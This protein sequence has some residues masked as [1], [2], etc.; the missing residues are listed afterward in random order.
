MSEPERKTANTLR[1]Q[2]KQQQRRMRRVRAL[3]FALVGISVVLLAVWQWITAPPSG[4]HQ[5]IAVDIP[6][7]TRSP[8]IGSLLEAKGVI[9]SAYAFVLQTRLDGAGNELKAGRYTLSGDMPLQQVIDSL[10]RGPAQDDEGIHVTIPEGYTLK[11]IAA[12]MDERGVTDGGELYRLATDAT[13]IADLQADFALPKTTLEGYLFPDTYTFKSRT[14]PAK[15]LESLL[16]NFGTR[17]ARPYSQEI[18]ASGRSLHD[19]V[20]IASLIEREARVPEDRARIAGVID[21][22]LKRHMRLEIDATVLYALGFHKSRVLYKDLNV[23]SPY[24]TYRHAGLPPGPI[25]NPG[26]PCLL[27]AL[28]PEQHDFVYYVARPNG[29]HIFSRTASEHALA[30]RQAR[31]ERKQQSATPDKL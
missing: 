15:V 9:R 23:K 17:F 13:A 8:D 27:A 1:A 6:H 21:N 14:S 22:R 10:K 28:H 11:Q 31:A 5:A 12:L 16:A 30:I 26:L 2:A 4:S 20:T 29:A 7:G 24:N 3:L 25:A 19:V 18:G